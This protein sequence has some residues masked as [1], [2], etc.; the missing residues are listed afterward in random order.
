MSSAVTLII[1]HINNRNN[2]NPVMPMTHAY[3]TIRPHVLQTL[4]CEMRTLMMSWHC[5]Y[6]RLRFSYPGYVTMQN[7]MALTRYLEKLF[8]RK[9]D[10]VSKKWLSPYLRPDY[11]E[12]EVVW[13]EG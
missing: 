1:S 2:G 11:I 12:S 9:V 10:L 7:V 4:S 5:H 8:G 3:Q 13:C 6:W